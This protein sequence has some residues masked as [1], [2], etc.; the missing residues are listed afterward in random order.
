MYEYLVGTFLLGAVWLVIFLLRKD[1]RHAMI[2]SAWFYVIL[3]TVGFILLYI[4]NINPSVRIN[5]GYWTP[6]T[7]FNL[8]NKTGGFAIEDALF[9]FFIAGI[10]AAAYETLTGMRVQKKTDKRLKKHHALWFGLIGAAVGCLMLN[11]NG[12]YL[13]I[14]FNL[15]GGLAIIYQRPDLAKQAIFSGLIMLFIY[16]ALFSLFNILFPDFINLYYNLERTTKMIIMGIP[17]E[18]YLFALTFGFI[19][20]PLYEYEHRVKDRRIGKLSSKINTS[21]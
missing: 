12:M 11:L 6:P 1:L 21:R 16:W 14:F 4:A 10:A 18:E 8:N 20:A 7:L 5:P 9:M 2:W 13:L 15:F 19:W 3:L 17:L